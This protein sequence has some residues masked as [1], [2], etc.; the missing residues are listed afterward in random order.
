MNVWLK[1]IIALV[2]VVTI[3]SLIFPDK[4][5]GKLVKGIFS[6]IIVVTFL[7]PFLSLNNLFIDYEYDTFNSQVFNDYNYDYLDYTFDKKSR[8]I[9]KDIEDFILSKYGFV[10]KA[11]VIYDVSDNLQYL[12]KNIKININFDGFYKDNEHIVV[13]EEIKSFLSSNY[14]LSKNL[15]DING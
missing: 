1:Q 13:I 5:T 14:N 15:V 8:L 6:I 10:S 3:I 12:I 9:E 2:I 11:T 7:N 4:Q